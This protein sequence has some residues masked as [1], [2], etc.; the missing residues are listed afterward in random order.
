MTTKSKTEFTA[1]YYNQAG[2]LIFSLTIPSIDRAR[3]LAKDHNNNLPNGSLLIHEIKIFD[4]EG[5]GINGYLFDPIY[6]K[7]KRRN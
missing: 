3:R 4:E 5:N 2:D 6:S 1:K 7:F